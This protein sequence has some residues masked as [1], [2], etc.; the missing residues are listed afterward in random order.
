MSYQQVEEIELGALPGTVEEIEAVAVAVAEVPGEVTSLQK[1]TGHLPPLWRNRDYMLLWSGQTI[2]SIGSAGS[3]IVFPLLI[4]AIT[5]SPVAAGIAG[6]LYTVPYLLFSLPVG[7][8][9]DRWNR[10]KV[11]ILCDVGRAVSLASVPLAIAFGALTAWQLYANAFIEGTLFVFFNVAEVAC[12]PRVVSKAQLPAAT[13]Q[14][15]ISM[16]TSALVGPPL[17]GYLFQALGRPF[18]FIVDAISYVASVFSLLFIKTEFQGERLAAKRDLRAEIMEGLSWL[19]EQRVV[20]T[21]AI[22]T[23]GLNFANAATWLIIIVLA[24]QLGA[25]PTVIGALISVGAAGGIIGAL[26]GGRV[27]KRFRFGQ[28]IVA[29]ILIETLAFPL[30]AI[31][32]NIIV[33]GLV[34]AIIW[35]TIPV[36]NVTALSYRVALIPDALQGRVNSASRL[37]SW[38]TQPAGAFLSGLFLQWFGPVPTILI[39]FA[40]LL[41]VSAF[42]IFNPYVHNAPPI[43][44]LQ[45]V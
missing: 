18:P 1:Q 27:Q 25:N 11:M 3:G 30:Y 22:I 21:M 13:A 14:N 36:Y 15:E 43:E 4:L 41:G 32:P 16:S 12:L 35:L 10:K 5:K 19:W 23:G 2:S 7:A 24:T 20:R 26:V 9:I 40:C 33:L 45:M 17:G 39:F 44:E 42:A 31:A 29:T 34:S 28:V 6:A 38:G 37:I 8:L